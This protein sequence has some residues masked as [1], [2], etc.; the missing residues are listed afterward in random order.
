MNAELKTRKDA[1]THAFLLQYIIVSLDGQCK[2]TGSVIF[3]HVAEESG[4][5][6]RVCSHNCGMFS[7]SIHESLRPSQKYV[8]LS[9]QGL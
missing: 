8:V 6:A 7:R 4:W 9:Y 3:G 1:D 2:S 5:E